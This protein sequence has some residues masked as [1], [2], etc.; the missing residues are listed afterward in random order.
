MMISINS[1]KQ[2]LNKYL[3]NKIFIVLKRLW[4]LS[5]RLLNKQY[6]IIKY[7]NTIVLYP[8]SDSTG[9]HNQPEIIDYLLD[10]KTGG[11]F[12]DIGANHP[13]NNSNTHFFEKQRKYSGMAFDPL[14]KY[15]ALW[16]EERPRT[17]FKNVALGASAG[18]ITFVEFANTDGW[19]DQLSFTSDS[20]LFDSKH[21]TGK[22]VKVERL[23]HISDVPSDIDFL[24]LDV[25]GAELAVLHGLGSVVR[26]RIMLVENCFGI[27]GNRE[28][29]EFMLA[30]GYQFVI[31]ISYIDDL[32]VRLD[33]HVIMKNVSTLPRDLAHLVSKSWA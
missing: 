7:P 13:Q 11:Y 18:E 26:P 8:N 21:M 3:P 4:Q 30:I 6:F 2:I 20:P 5:R 33:Q 25:E 14:Q 22:P 15:A 27:A 17:A 9:Q 29:R 19:Q 23:D 12:I 31:R 32:Y 28:I 10:R 16:A 1:L 24:S